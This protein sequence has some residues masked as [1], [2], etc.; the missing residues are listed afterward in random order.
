MTPRPAGG[1][2]SGRRLS[3]LRL[4]LDS[5]L[6]CH[7]ESGD[8]VQARRRRAAAAAAGSPP[9]E[10][11]SGPASPSRR[12]TESLARHPAGEIIKLNVAARVT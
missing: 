10:S 1:P 12:A 5:E 6:S 9:S 4:R 3:G 11:E 2:D 8:S 7:S